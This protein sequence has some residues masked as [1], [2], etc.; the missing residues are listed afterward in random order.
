MGGLKFH[1]MIIRISNSLRNFILTIANFGT[2]LTYMQ[3]RSR[4]TTLRVS[5]TL[6]NSS[7]YPV[8]LSDHDANT[9]Y[10]NC[11][12]YVI[13]SNTKIHSTKIQVFDSKTYLV[14]KNYRKTFKPLKEVELFSKV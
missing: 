1:H 3:N 9:N 14:D 8:A 13:R 6:N 12:R 5:N 4:W 10:L 2:L 11:F 7:V